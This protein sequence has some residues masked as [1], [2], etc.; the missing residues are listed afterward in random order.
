MLMVPS[1]GR[2][3]P[4]KIGVNAKLKAS[5]MVYSVAPCCKLVVNIRQ[6][7]IKDLGESMP[8][9]TQPCEDQMSSFRLSR[10]YKL[11]SP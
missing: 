11:H 6:L 3:R 4:K 5:W 8:L 10:P 7:Y 1:I 9:P 2:R